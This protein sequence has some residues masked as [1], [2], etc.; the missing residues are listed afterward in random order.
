MNLHLAGSRYAFCACSEAFPL[1]RSS[2]SWYYQA[3]SVNFHLFQI[4]VKTI[5]RCIQHLRLRLA[6]GLSAWANRLF[7]IRYFG[8]ARRVGCPDLSRA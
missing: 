4:T 6:P 2:V 7:S 1:S 3:I 8:R 5:L